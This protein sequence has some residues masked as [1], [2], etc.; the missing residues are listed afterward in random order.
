MP[1]TERPRQCPEC[2][3]IP[4]KSKTWNLAMKQDDL[5]GRLRMR[6]EELSEENK[7]LNKELDAYRINKNGND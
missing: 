2:G 7:Q 4:V 5:L 3:M 6:V 1:K